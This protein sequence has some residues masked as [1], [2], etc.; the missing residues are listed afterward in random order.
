M[1]TALEVAP[2]DPAIGS[3][4]AVRLGEIESFLFRC[5]EAGQQEGSVSA[6]R[7]P[8]DLARLLLAV[9]MGMRV[10]ARAPGP[11]PP[12]GRVAAGALVARSPG[13]GGNAMMGTEASVRVVPHTPIPSPHPYPGPRPSMA[14]ACGGSPD[15]H[16]VV[17]GIMTSSHF[18]RLAALLITLLPTNGL[19]RAAYR[20]ALGYEIHPTAR[21]DA[22]SF[23]SVAR[24][25]LGP[26]AHLERFN[27]FSG[28]LSLTVGA[29]SSI[30]SSNQIR[31]GIWTGAAAP[32]DHGARYQQRMVVGDGCRISPGH[33]FD[34][35]GEILIGDRCWIAGRGSQFW[36]HGA[37]TPRSTVHIGAD[38][39][40][41]SACRFAPGAAI[42]DNTVVSLGSVVTRSFSTPYRLLGGVPAKELRDIEDDIRS[43]R[44]FAGRWTEASGV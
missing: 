41:G 13:T 34:A 21:V 16:R 14:G 23:I 39:F 2:H 37:S 7:P 17:I 10:L 1:N 25:V 9:L 32:S 43:K 12:A 5:V 20:W 19:R 15:P 8:E 42:A 4:V 11:W 29:R 30:A 38:C 33:F 31:C 27:L 36:T 44:L 35:N 40:I 24:L 18:R 3:A 6:E 28:P 26:G 22:L